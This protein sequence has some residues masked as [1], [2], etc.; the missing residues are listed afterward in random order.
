MILQALTRYYETLVESG[1]IAAAGWDPVKVSY[2]INVDAEGHFRGIQSLLVKG[3]KG[4]KEVM[5]PCIQNVPRHATRS[6]KTPPPY[7]LCD[8]A[9]YLLGAWAETQDAAENK[10]RREKAQEYF[11]NAANYHRE[12][13]KSCD[14]PAARGVCLFFETWN[15]ESQKEEITIPIEEIVNAPNLVFR[16]WD[17]GAYV[18]GEEK[19]REI[20]N[21]AYSGSSGEVVGQCLITGKMAPIARLHPMI[22]GVR[23]AQSSGA[24]LV[25]FNAPAFESYEKQQGMNAPVSEYAANAYGG[26]LNYLL[27]QTKYGSVIGAETVVYWAETGEDVYADFFEECL[28][29]DGDDELKLINT[30]KAIARGERCEEQDSQIDPN[31]KFYILGL[32]PNAARLSVRFFYANTFGNLIQ[33]VLAH[34]RR[35]EIQ[36]PVYEK[37]EYPGIGNILAETVPRNA[38]EKTVASI[39]VG[40][41]FR[42]VLHNTRYPTTIFNSI[43][44]RIRSDHFTNRNRAAMIKAYLMKNKPET[45]EVVGKMELNETT[46][47][48]A[49]VLG[50]I[51]A[52]LEGIQKEANPN[53][54]A[55][56]KDRYF[57]SACATPA[58]VF[59]QLLKLANNHLKVVSREK[60]GWGVTLEKQL[61]ALMECLDTSFPSHLTLEEQG[62][63]ILGYYHET[64]KRY[65][66]KA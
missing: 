33:N 11:Q 54:N 15:F 32:S 28:F 66:P 49:Y 40:E 24:A 46:K 65:A 41:L 26:A 37:K 36:K 53:L 10:K 62:I 3:M 59:P 18:L 23:G 27:S 61:G 57:N 39:L 16:F 14:D 58:V 34:Y 64:Q 22:K 20:W 44:I 42:A 6:G 51:F 5:V 1:K 19:I 9:K 38:K 2:A 43:I 12:L 8:N 63:F 35:L 48:A 45:E 56:I 47:N 21:E 60:K 31:T 50:R 55:T 30:M 13:L 4:K 29:D 17:T 7:F 52:V 25:A